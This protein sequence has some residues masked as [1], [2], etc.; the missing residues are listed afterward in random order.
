MYVIV[1]LIFF[2]LACR[3]FIGLFIILMLLEGRRDIHRRPIGGEY[4][5]CTPSEVQQTGG[6]VGIV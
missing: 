3:V 1:D 4:S 5:H 6:S 2:V